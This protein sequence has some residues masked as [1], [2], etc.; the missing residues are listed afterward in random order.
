MR[1]VIVFLTFTTLLLIGE[2]RILAQGGDE[3]SCI[4]SA[5]SDV[6]VRTDTTTFSDVLDVLSVGDSRTVIGQIMGSDGLMW[7][8]L[9]SGGWVREDVVVAS[10][11]CAFQQVTL[12]IFNDFDVPIC[13]VNFILSLDPDTSWGSDRLSNT[14]TIQPGAERRWVIVPGIYDIWLGDCDEETL[15]EIYEVHV[16]EDYRLDIVPLPVTPVRF[17]DAIEANRLGQQADEQGRYDEALSHYEKALMIVHILNMRDGEGIILNNIG[18]VYVH[19]GQFEQALNF[20]QQSVT[21]AR[22]IGNRAGEAMT[23]D[24]LGAV[25]ADQGRYKLAIDYHQQALAIFRDLNDEPHAGIALSNLGRVYGLQ[26]Q[27]NLA[28]DHFQQALNIHREANDL[29]Q[30]GAAL[31]NIGRVYEEWGQYDLARDY[32]QQALA[33]V[34][35]VGNRQGEGIILDNIGAVFCSQGLFG[36]AL[37]YHHQALAIRQE[38]GDRKGEAVTLGNMGRV[39]RG[40]GQNELALDCYQQSLIITSEIYGGEGDGTT[41]GNIGQVYYELGQYEMAL[42][43]Y[44]QALVAVRD[45][46]NPASEAIIL[47][48]I[49]A[50]HAEQ[51]QYVQALDF[52]QQALSIQ[53]ELGARS[54][55][56]S[57]LV[58]IGAV[59]VEEG[60]YLQALGYLEQALAIFRDTGDLDNKLGTLITIGLMYERAQETPDQAI[61][62]YQQAVDVHEN[63]LRSAALDQAIIDLAGENMPLYTHLSNL[64]VQDGDL[65]GAL[66]YTER[67]RSVLLRNNLRSGTIDFSANLDDQSLLDEEERLRLTV[68]SAQN[69]VNALNQDLS[70]TN[71]DKQNAQESLDEAR[72]VYES[73]L[74]RMQL[75]GG[76]LARELALDVASLAEIQAAL[77]GDTT[78]VLY[79]IGGQGGYA[80]L[81]TPDDLRGFILEATTEDIDAAMRA[82]AADRQASV[83]ALQG[84]YSLIFAPIADEITTDSLIISPDDV[85][86]YVPFAALQAPDGSY[87]ID[88]Y[89]IS[90]IPSGTALVLLN[91][92]E[93][94]SPASSPGLVL[95]QRDAQGLPRL[96]YAYSEAEAIAGELGVTAVTD[97]SESD[98][99]AGSTGA[100]VVYISTHVEL[101]RFAPLFSVIHLGADDTYDGRFEVREIYELDLSQGTELVILSGCE[102]A[103]GGKGEDFGLLSR[104]FFA[105]G[106][107]R[108]VASLW[109][110]DDAA[111][112]ELLTTF[113]E[114][115]TETGNDAEALRTAMLATRE[116]H[117]EPY[118]WASFVLNGLP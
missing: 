66:E 38:I 7:W 39:Y 19:L 6:N 37:D 99:R 26:G 5:T 76:F 100:E 59:Y 36:Q 102:T 103:S 45:M 63:L 32:Y 87:L 8:Q 17:G 64:L 114:V 68:S 85:L 95:A 111:T 58:S 112:A 115:R 47:N 84:L 101:D 16:T 106:A 104:A 31:N 75:Q 71:Q 113:I 109:R 52:F 61:D 97:A 108:V 54:Y 28:L 94:S 56:G 49:G 89:T 44:Q 82:F 29:G 4:V 15:A 80:L 3:G 42:D 73:H 50:L 12:T 69:Q 70:A 24:N 72:T 53:R 11:N 96:R 55:E 18:M 74:E 117:P 33:I 41:L 118:Y 105:A 46:E 9:E 48:R 88:H 20:Y 60:Q 35:E 81:V 110:V 116:S 40:L 57:A 2:G 67:G 34:Q 83:N 13:Y 10:G 107:P 90:M 79:G 92:R 78:L 51:G 25:S 62:Y 21:I 86:N 91:E 77:S 27:Y 98:L 22:E 30:E 23:L 93:S 14:E 1:K 43:Y 65:L